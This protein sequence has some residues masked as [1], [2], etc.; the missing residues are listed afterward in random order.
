MLSGGEPT[1]H[2]D[3][4][5]ILKEAT[6]RTSPAWCSIPTA[7]ASPKTTSFVDALHKLRDRVEIYMQFDGFSL[8]THMYHRAKDLREIKAA[9]IERLAR[10]RVFT[11]LVM[12]VAQGVNDGE[13]GECREYAFDTDYIAGV[14]FQPVFGSG[15]A[16]PIDP[17]NRVTTTGVMKRL[18]EQTGGLVGPEDFIALPC[19]HPD[20]CSITY[21]V[22]GD[23]GSSTRSPDCWA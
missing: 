18:G 7:S 2:P 23:R 8:E 16:N 14:S 10:A 13:V 5:E 4:I 20:C 11:T 21:F 15:R 17:M 19:S 1:V 3:L 12:A 6:A 22:R 9:A